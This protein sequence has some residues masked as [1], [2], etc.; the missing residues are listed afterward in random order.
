MNYE[1]EELL[2]IVAEVA[3]KYTGCDSTSVTYEQAQMLMEGVIYCLDECGH[4]VKEEVFSKELSVAEQYRIGAGLVFEKV[5]EIRKIYNEMSLDFEDYGV[6]CLRDTVRKGI[7]EFL[8]WYDI[9]YCPQNTIL[10]LDYPLL[11]DICSL[12]GADAVYEF[13]HAVK[14]EQNFLEIFDKDYVTEILRRAVPDYKNM[15]EN[16]C[17]ILLTNTIG[18]IAV[19]KPLSD[20]GFTKEEYARLSE[21]FSG[22]SV[23]GIEG[24]IRQ[25]VEKMII[26]IYEDNRELLEYLQHDIKNMAFRI[27]I[28]VKNGQLNKLFVM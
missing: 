19:R 2:P 7:P 18:H 5:S 10:T 14:L 23:S 25:L 20:N 22:E 13:I 11:K 24:I 6:R 15:I 4:S 8:K 3:Q 26:Q 21:I 12:K 9:K 16:I 17:D 1:M 28:G 27:E